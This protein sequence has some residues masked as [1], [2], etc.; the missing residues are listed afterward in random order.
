MDYNPYYIRYRP[1]YQNPQTGF[2]FDPSKGLVRNQQ[3]FASEPQFGYNFDTSSG[4]LKRYG[5]QANYQPSQ[6]FDVNA[7]LNTAADIAG[8]ASGLVSSATESLNLGKP[9]PQYFQEGVDP[10]YQGG[11]YFNRVYSARPSGAGAGEIV[12][13]AAQGAKIGAQFGG[14]IIGAGIGA[15]VGALGSI[16]AGEIRRARQRREKRKALDLAMGQQ[17]A[18]NTAQEEYDRQKMAQQEY[19]RMANPYRR[20]QNL[21]SV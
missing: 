9:A 1:S 12:S 13:G 18:F 4:Q 11:E 15:A 5:S 10:S 6:G 21:Y 17:Q 7:G 19:T 8:Y 20:M 3:M 2:T 16:G 14:G